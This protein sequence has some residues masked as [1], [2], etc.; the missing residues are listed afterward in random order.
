MLRDDRIGQL[1]YRFNVFETSLDRL[2]SAVHGSEMDH[3]AELRTLPAF[4]A[5]REFVAMVRGKSF[6]AVALVSMLRSMQ[7]QAGSDEP[8]E[9]R[10]A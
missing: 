5:L 4:I 1:A 3:K 7:T 9:V 10:P 6:E 2:W 8:L